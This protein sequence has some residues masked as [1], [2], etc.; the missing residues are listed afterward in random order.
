MISYTFDTG[1]SINYSN[2][3]SQMLLKII[4]IR[5]KTRISNKVI[6]ICA[7]TLLQLIIYLESN[8]KEIFLRKYSKEDKNYY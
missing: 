5:K 3:S 7:I 6:T 4:V 1:A 8:Q 2:I